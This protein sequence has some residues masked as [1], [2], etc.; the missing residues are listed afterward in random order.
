MRAGGSSEPCDTL[1]KA[2]IFSSWSLPWSTPRREADF[3]SHLRGALAEDGRGQLLPGSLTRER[4]KFW[5]SPMMTP[6]E[7]AVWSAA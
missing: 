7:N 6:S 4:V 2:P 3:V 1:Q 5:L